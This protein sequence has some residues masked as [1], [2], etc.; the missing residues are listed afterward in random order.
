MTRINLIQKLNFIF[1]TDHY[2]NLTFDFSNHS[3]NRDYLANI[4]LYKSYN[5]DIFNIN[6]F[7]SLSDIRNTV[8]SMKNYKYFESDNIPLDFI[9]HF[10]VTNIWKKISFC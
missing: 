7:I 5:Q 4:S 3:L 1:W 6:D 8:S 10:S 2:K 9:K